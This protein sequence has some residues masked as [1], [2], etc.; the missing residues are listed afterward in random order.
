[1]WTLTDLYNGIQHCIRIVIK[2]PS[3]KKLSD[4]YNNHDNH[5]LLRQCPLNGG[6][7]IIVPITEIIISLL[8]YPLS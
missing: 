7:T 3:F 2:Y 5:I 1:M 6:T 4:F 8:R